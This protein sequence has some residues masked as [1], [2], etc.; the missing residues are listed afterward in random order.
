MRLTVKQLAALHEADKD[1]IFQLPER[2]RHSPG[3][4]ATLVRAGLLEATS[5]GVIWNITDAGRAKLA[6]LRSETGNPSVVPRTSTTVAALE[7]TEW[8]KQFKVDSPVS[9]KA[10]LQYALQ[11]EL[12]VFIERSFETGDP[13]WAVRVFDDPEFWMEAK[14]TKVQAIELCR[15]MGWKIVE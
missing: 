12:S 15:E 11:D 2:R 5:V 3:V 1:K 4:L 14:P 7:Q 9:Y 13:V 10:A 8:A 6:C